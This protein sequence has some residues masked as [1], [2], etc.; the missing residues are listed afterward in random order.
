MSRRFGQEDDDEMR[1]ARAKHAAADAAEHRA[2]QRHSEEL[3][4]QSERQRQ[5]ESGKRQGAWSFEEIL[6]G[7]GKVSG[8]S[9]LL[10]GKLEGMLIV[11]PRGDLVALASGDSERGDPSAEEILAAFLAYRSP[12]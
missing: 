10:N 1:R 8:W 2:D 12:Q 3:W 9:V 4:R 6:N 5:R 7:S 11:H